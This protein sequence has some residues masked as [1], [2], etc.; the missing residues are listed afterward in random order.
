[1]WWCAAHGKR[2]QNVDTVYGARG[3]F[4]HAPCVTARIL[5]PSTPFW[6]RAPRAHTPFF[7]HEYAHI[8]PPP[9]PP[10]SAAP[11]AQDTPSFV[12]GAA[13]CLLACVP[14]LLALLMHAHQGW[15]ECSHAMNTSA[16]AH[17]A[18]RVGC[19]GDYGGV[20][21][22]RATGLPMLTRCVWA[23][24]LCGA[25]LLCVG[26]PYTVHYNHIEHTRKPTDAQRS[27]HIH[28]HVAIMLCS[29]A[30]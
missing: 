20:G 4:V 30:A 23:A 28:T 26:C 1:M 11:C 27:H 9:Q 13:H 3:V 22:V 10:C 24:L 5:D 6:V 18:A 19:H 25:A 16:A 7:K 12:A 14:S 21:G 15:A 2:T 29:V 17:V 8:P